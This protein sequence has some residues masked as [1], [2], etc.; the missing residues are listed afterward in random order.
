MRLYGRKVVLG[1]CGGIAAYKAVELL[2]LLMQEGADVHV[3]MTRA[4]SRFVTPLTFRALSG[5][6]VLTALYEEDLGGEAGHA[7]ESGVEHIEL[8]KDADVIVVAPA[9]ANTLAKGAW[10]LAD[11]ALSTVLVAAGTDLLWAPAMNHRM[12]KNAITQDNVV[13][14][15]RLGHVVVDPEA[16]WMACREHGVGRM[17][18]PETIV[19][20]VVELI[21]HPQDLAGVRVLVTAG[22]TE[23][24]IDAVRVL[25]NRSSGRMGVALAEEA[26]DRGARV[27]LLAGPM[28][29]AAPEGVVCERIVTAE[30]M[31]DAA[32]RLFADSDVLVMAA[33]VG[34]F[35]RN[36]AKGGEKLRRTEEGIELSLSANP[37][38]LSRLADRRR[39][40]Q[41]LVGFALEAGEAEK[42][43]REKL[44]RKGVDLMVVNHPDA[45]IGSET[46]LVTLMEAGKRSR[47][48]PELPKREVARRIIDWV[49]ARREVGQGGKRA[50]STRRTRRA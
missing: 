21:G 3:V 17:A 15:K 50:R 24:P 27:T 26:R 31:A 39:A 46:N 42:R 4:A 20:H 9:T 22:R 5:H 45:A 28:D 40:D 23:E 37:D 19:E 30:E 29:V 13:R 2:R 48:L 38:I 49:A 1:V 18:E 35:R 41:V 12:W 7:D 47:K 6:P 10:G 25:T 36:G 16:G 11:D 32:D 44:K 43:G 14:L 33:A 34:D 8:V